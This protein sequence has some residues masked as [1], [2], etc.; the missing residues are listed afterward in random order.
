MLAT[1]APGPFSRPGW[2][3][4]PKYDGFRILARKERGAVRLITRN[5]FDLAKAFPELVIELETLPDVVMDGELVVLDEHGHPQFDSL[6]RRARMTRLPPRRWRGKNGRSRLP[7]SGR[8]KRSGL[9]I[10]V[11]EKRAIVRVKQRG[12]SPARDRGARWCGSPQCKR[13]IG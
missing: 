1:S 8:R 2:L 4:E 10:S 7:P 3:F 13:G 12:I 6:R 5:G 11:N 9:S